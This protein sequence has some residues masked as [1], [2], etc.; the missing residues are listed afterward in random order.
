MS[1]FLLVSDR[2]GHNILGPGP[3]SGASESSGSQERGQA[4]SGTVQV[5]LV[6]PGG[7]THRELQSEDWWARSEH[8]VHGA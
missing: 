2:A 4:S 7:Q 1:A 6:E 8:E 5:F 3:L